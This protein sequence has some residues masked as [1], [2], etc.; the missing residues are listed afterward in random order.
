MHV[1]DEIVRNASSTQELQRNE[2][3]GTINCVH[4]DT[5]RAVVYNGFQAFC[6][7]QV[8]FSEG[9]EPHRRVAEIRLF[10]SCI[11][12]KRVAK[13]RLATDCLANISD[14][15]VN[16]AKTRTGQVCFIEIG[17]DELGSIKG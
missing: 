4:S 9:D 3:L 15:K 13:V 10:K 14:M 11:S 7:A 12:K 1:F 8:A 17:V 16:S 5:G 2:A 6:L